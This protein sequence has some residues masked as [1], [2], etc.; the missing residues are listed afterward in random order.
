MQGTTIMLIGVVAVLVL[1]VLI[2]L[3]VRIYREGDGLGGLFKVLPVFFVALMAVIV[4]A[5]ITEEVT[6]YS[7]DD[8]SGTLTITG[9]VY[10]DYS[11]WDDYADNI[12]SLIIQDNAKISSGAFDTLT[13]LAYVSIGKGA[14]V[15]QEDFG[16]AF[17]DYTDATVS[18]QKGIYAG[19]GD[20]T[21]YK[22]ESTILVSS[23]GGVSL[24]PASSGVKNVVIPESIDGTAIT[25]ISDTGFSESGII[26]VVVIGNSL[27]AIGY[28]AFKNCASL[29]AIN[30]P[31]SVVT[32][33]G[34][35]FMGT[36]ITSIS[37]GMVTTLGNSVF[38]GCTSLTTA[39]FK[40]MPSQLLTSVF[41]DCVSL[42]SITIPEGVTSIGND[43]FNGCTSLKTVTLPD[44]LTTIN[45]GV[46]IGCTGIESVTFGTGLS[47]IQT[48][49]FS[50]WTFYESDGTTTLAKTAANLAGKTFQGT[51]VALVEVLPDRSSLTPDQIQKVRLHDAELQDLKDQITLELPFQPSLQEELTA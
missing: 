48:N 2:T 10:Q 9:N 8:R 26:R 35:S 25:K 50:A 13:N 19:Y 27:T 14:E 1:I 21:L 6:P 22:Y 45:Y 39:T 38:N 33:P 3:V 15:S 36:D 43:C 31:D 46:F 28:R 49:A 41:K 18:P 20:G 16:V 4:L 7:Y 32:I 34:E 5:Q 17:K 42:E 29:S 51:A 23:G 37:A 47:S 40:G 30:L 44:S 12:R 24:N 11:P